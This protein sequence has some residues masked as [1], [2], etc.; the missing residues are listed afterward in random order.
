MSLQPPVQILQA[1]AKERSAQEG[2]AQ[3]FPQAAQ[4][5]PPVAAGPSPSEVQV[6]PTKGEAAPLAKEAGR[7]SSKGGDSVSD[8]LCAVIAFSPDTTLLTEACALPTP[9]VPNKHHRAVGYCPRSPTS[10]NAP[11][12]AVGYPHDRLARTS[13]G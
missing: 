9:G 2:K 3:A 11:Y 10:H 8:V 4:H 5:G 1:E 13:V 7:W 12:L 6:S